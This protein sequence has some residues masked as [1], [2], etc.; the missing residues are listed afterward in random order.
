[1]E[2]AEAVTVDRAKW[3]PW[4]ISFGRPWQFLRQDN[5]QGRH[6]PDGRVGGSSA[7]RR[8]RKPKDRVSIWIWRW[9]DVIF[10]C[11]AESGSL[12]RYHLKGSRG[13][14]THLLSD[15]YVWVTNVC[16]W[17][18]F[19]WKVIVVDQLYCYH[20]LSPEVTD[21]ENSYWPSEN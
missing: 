10:D 13:W 19:L 3:R 8:F 6:R 21:D 16:Y 17:I 1:M 4:A 12:I 2:Q 20:F 15:A 18:M 11:N 14:G 9:K 7:S 5:F